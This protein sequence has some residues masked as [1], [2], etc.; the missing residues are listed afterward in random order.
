MVFKC[1]REKH[2]IF[3]SGNKAF[4]GRIRLNLLLITGY[5]VWRKWNNIA[6]QIFFMLIK[7]DEN[8]PGFKPCKKKKI[9]YND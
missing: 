5:T 8:V 2:L 6:F 7:P 4:F 3:F 1:F 9:P